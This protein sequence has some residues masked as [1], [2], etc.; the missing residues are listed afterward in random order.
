[1]WA[2]RQSPYVVPGNLDEALRTFHDRLPC[3]D[4]DMLKVSQDQLF[5]TVYKLACEIPEIAAWNEPKSGHGQ[6]LVFSSRYDQPSP[7]DD[8]IDLSALANNV[9]RSCIAEERECDLSPA[10]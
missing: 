10:D 3:D 4:L 7:D 1:M 8:I 6:T 5:N 9:A 2:V